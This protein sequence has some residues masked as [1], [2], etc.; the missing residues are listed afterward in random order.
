MLPQFAAAGFTNTALT[1]W[2][3]Q[4]YSRYN[5]L[6]LQLNRRFSNGLQLVG[7][8]TWS[9]LISNSDAEFATTFLTPRRPE[10]YQNLALDQS[11]SALDRRHRFT[12][13]AI[14]DV[15][16][17]KNG[18]WFMKNIV[19]NWE[20]APIYTYEAPGNPGLRRATQTRI[21]TEIGRRTARS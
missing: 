3:P 2:T 18:N 4:G 11:N 8:Y 6:A 19:G 5:G 15:P 12:F 20:V 17:Y 16:W 1:E 10:F 14:Y 21:S 7:A 13:S 9:H